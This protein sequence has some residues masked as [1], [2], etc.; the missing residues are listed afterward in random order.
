MPIPHHNAFIRLACLS[1][2]VYSMRHT[3]I[4][5]QDHYEVWWMDTLHSYL[6]I[7]EEGP[8]TNVFLRAVGHRK[9]Q[10]YDLLPGRHHKLARVTV[11]KQL[12]ETHETS[13]ITRRSQMRPEWNKIEK[14]K[15]EGRISK[16]SERPRTVCLRTCLNDS[17]LFFWIK[18][19]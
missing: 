9:M 6:W 19:N 10:K 11:I 18:R 16:S 5:L 4:D 15:L 3:C 7:N 13:F 2:N 12:L 14:W 17:E 8:R 1:V